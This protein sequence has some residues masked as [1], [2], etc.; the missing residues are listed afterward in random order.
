MKFYIK[1]IV[2]WLDNGYKR[3][4]GEFENNKVNIITGDPSKGKSSILEIL[5]Y[6]F[7]SSE[8]TV[9][10]GDD[11]I[12]RVEWF[13]INFC[14]NNKTLT[15]ARHSSNMNNYYFSSS[16]DIPDN[17]YANAKE[18]NIKSVLHAEFSINDNVKFPFGGNF[19]KK[20]TK[21]SHRYFM[22][23]NTQT[24]DVLS[25]NKVLFDKQTDSKYQEALI[26]ILDIAL[27]V[28]NID[29]IIKN[30]K[31]KELENKKDRIEDKIDFL[32]TKKDNFIEEKTE[33]INKAKA[34]NLIEN[35]LSFDDAML[36]L[37]DMIKDINKL[38]TIDN[39]S[40][41]TN[42]EKRKLELKL[43]RSK[44]TKY[45]KQ[46][47]K[48][49]K[50]LKKDMDSLKPIKYLNSKMDELLQVNG[51]KNIVEAVEKELTAIKSFISNKDLPA[52]RELDTEIEEIN[53]DLTSIE[54]NINNLSS[55]EIEVDKLKSKQLIFLGELKSALKIYK[56]KIEDTDY[57]KQ[58]EELDIQ[59][60]NLKKEVIPI[61]RSDTLDTLSEYMQSIFRG[62]E[63]DLRGYSGYKP[64]FDFKDRL[65]KLK[66]IDEIIDMYDSE[67]IKNIGS[68]SNHLFLHLAFFTALHRLFIKKV[69]PSQFIPQFLI[70]DQPDSPFYETGSDTSEEKELFMKS[71][72]ILDNHIEYFQNE[73]HEDF[74]IIV[75]EHIEWKDIED[76]KFKHYKLIE[77]WREGSGLIPPEV[78][79]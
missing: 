34:L 32:K 18:K 71:L 35:N 60:N 33:L 43:K 55:N 8:N 64:I 17:I 21:I 28:T 27:G 40:E 67:T 16:G 45:K 57:S 39:S 30:E 65:I 4:L 70:L 7:L 20:N 2:L 68:S 9:V 56:T 76:E 63:F 15:I 49:K 42:L 73:L 51:L 13:G 3:E 54:E 24:R 62:V 29:N 53:T 14:I 47:E 72:N 59:I 19:I 41:I 74:Q 58:L 46:Y 50:S 11:Y 75:L 69:E 10:Q 37:S 48:Y 31:L 52:I 78:L 22:L 44:Y 26:R 6:C 5:D 25:H 1:K 38:E 61:D 12:D 66:K 77:E 79:V 23:F 36:G